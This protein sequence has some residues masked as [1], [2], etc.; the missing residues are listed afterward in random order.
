MMRFHPSSGQNNPKLAMI[1]DK[2]TLLFA[3]RRR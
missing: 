2:H 3:Q 1:D